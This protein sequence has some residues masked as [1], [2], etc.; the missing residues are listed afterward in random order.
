MS[1]PLKPCP[2]CGSTELI[3]GSLFVQCD[4]CGA[5]DH[6]TGWNNRPIEDD[7]RTRLAAAEERAIR[8]EQMRLKDAQDFSE[9]LYLAVE[10]VKKAEWERDEAMIQIDEEGDKK[11]RLLLNIDA[12]RIKAFEERDQARSELERVREAL[13]VL[14]EYAEQNECQHEETHLREVEGVLW[15]ICEGCN[16][17]WADDEGGFQPYQDPAAIAGARAALSPT[18][19]QPTATLECPCCGDVAAEGFVNDGDPLICGCNGIVSMDAENEPDVTCW[20]EEPDD[21]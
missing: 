17:R 6:A 2:F 8:S 7:L 3:P 11:R 21:D 13:A 5:D 18:P 15:T 12:K 14:L 16:Q 10:R 1:D 4:Q 9:E 20:D 19:P